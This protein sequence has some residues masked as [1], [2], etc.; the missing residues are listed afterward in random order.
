MSIKVPGVFISW[1]TSSRPFSILESYQ[2][3]IIIENGLKE[4]AA[5]IAFAFDLPIATI[6]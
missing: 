2:K 4:D 5:F 3:D 1:S 6:Y